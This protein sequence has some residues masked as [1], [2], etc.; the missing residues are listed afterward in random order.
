[1]GHGTYPPPS[2]I[3]RHLRKHLLAPPAPLSFTSPPPPTPAAH[4]SNSPKCQPFDS[5]KSAPKK[6]TC[7]SPAPIF[8]LQIPPPP[9]HTAAPP[10][11]PHSFSLPGQISQS[12]SSA[13]RIYR[14]H[15][16]SSKCRSTST[17][18]ISA[19]TCCTPTMCA[20]RPCARS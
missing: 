20:S 6:F 1:M 16:P 18:S 4:S 19:T 11:T 3:S 7:P 15:L 12:R 2:Q 14:R 9:S 10:L 13:R 8:H 17:S 5:P